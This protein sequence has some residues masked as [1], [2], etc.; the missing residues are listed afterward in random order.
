MIPLAHVLLAYLYQYVNF[1]LGA[2]AQA[3]PGT[4]AY[5]YNASTLGG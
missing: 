1:L 5:A 4:V 3:R 2:V